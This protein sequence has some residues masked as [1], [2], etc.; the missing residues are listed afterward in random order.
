MSIK[1]GRITDVAE[2]MKV[3]EAFRKVNQ[4]FDFELL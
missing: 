3:C 2:G 1:S 4:V